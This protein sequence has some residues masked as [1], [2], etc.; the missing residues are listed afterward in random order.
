MYLPADFKIIARYDFKKLY[1][2]LIV[3][4]PTVETHRMVSHSSEWAM[5]CDVHVGQHA[6][7]DLFLIKFA[8][9]LKLCNKIISCFVNFFSA[10][11]K[12]KTS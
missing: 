10:E 1:L 5:T 3:F 9:G 7:K 2:I 8:S 6:K 4:M 12:V 11:L